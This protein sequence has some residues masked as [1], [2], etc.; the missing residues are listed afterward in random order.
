MNIEALSG[1]ATLILFHL[2]RE[3]VYDMLRDSAL[4]QTTFLPSLKRESNE[5]LVG[6]WQNNMHVDIF[7]QA[8][9]NQ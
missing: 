7:S 1:I 2:L 3:F 9:V 6:R 8:L 5:S 4:Y